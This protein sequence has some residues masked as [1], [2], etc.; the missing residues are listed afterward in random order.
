MNSPAPL[1][2][3]VSWLIINE[4]MCR[5]LVTRCPN[6]R[7]RSHIPRGYVLLHIPEWGQEGHSVGAPVNAQRYKLIALF[8]KETVIIL[9]YNSL[10]MNYMIRLSVGERL[11][12]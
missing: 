12:C 11:N 8:V 6:H 10:G 4:R 1:N 2:A 7:R 5:T 3:L 9:L